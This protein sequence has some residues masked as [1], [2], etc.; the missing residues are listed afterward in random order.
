MFPFYLLL[1]LNAAKVARLQAAYREADGLGELNGIVHSLGLFDDRLKGLRG[2]TE[3]FLF[4]RDD[5]DVDPKTHKTRGIG[6]FGHHSFLIF[7]RDGGV[8][9][10]PPKDQFD[11]P[12]KSTREQWLRVP[13]NDGRPLMDSQAPHRRDSYA[14]S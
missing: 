12:R 3:A 14:L 13:R 6:E 8:P 2:V 1:R 5:F 10:V 4:G 9:V 11:I 7:C